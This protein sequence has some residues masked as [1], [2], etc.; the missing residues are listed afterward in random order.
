[1]YVRKNVKITIWTKKLRFYNISLSSICYF[2]CRPTLKDHFIGHSDCHLSGCIAYEWQ[3]PKWPTLS[4]LIKH[5]FQLFLFVAIV[6]W[7]RISHIEQNIIYKDD[8]TSIFILEWLS[9]LVTVDSFICNGLRLWMLFDMYWVL[10][11]ILP[12]HCYSHHLVTVTVDR[13]KQNG[14]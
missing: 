5:K 7:N 9:N 12:W 4:I 2:C 14:Q 10:I 3:C 6:I 8:K 13:L 1:M 11:L